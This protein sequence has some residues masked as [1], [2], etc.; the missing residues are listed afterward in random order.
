MHATIEL[1]F[2]S[3]SICSATLP[4]A[5]SRPRNC[6]LRLL[7]GVRRGVHRSLQVRD[8]GADGSIVHKAVAPRHVLEEPVAARTEVRN[9][10][11]HCLAQERIGR[12]GKL[13]E[14]FFIWRSASMRTSRP[15]SW[16]EG[17]RG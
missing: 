15:W 6:R 3:L 9:L 10:P 14:I 11:G 8:V 4:E 7:L 2:D 1:G 13:F 5:P 12:T 17:L 16:T